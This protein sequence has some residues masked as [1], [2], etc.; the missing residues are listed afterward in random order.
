MVLHHLLI[1]IK[2]RL[3]ISI[4]YQSAATILLTHWIMR[5]TINDQT[6][7]T[8]INDDGLTEAGQGKAEF[9]EQGSSVSGIAYWMGPGV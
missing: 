3:C 5:K 4:G 7:K 9:N 1:R 2:I 8:Q 6:E